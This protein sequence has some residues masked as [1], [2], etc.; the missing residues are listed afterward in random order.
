MIYG[1]GPFADLQR[2]LDQPNVCFGDL[3]FNA[4]ISWQLFNDKECSDRNDRNALLD[5]AV[6]HSCVIVLQLMNH[7]ASRYKMYCWVQHQ[8]DARVLTMTLTALD[9]LQQP[10][11][12]DLVKLL[13]YK[14]SASDM[15]PSPITRE[16]LVELSKG[17]RPEDSVPPPSTGEQRHT[18]R[19][20]VYVYALSNPS[21][22]CWINQGNVLV[23]AN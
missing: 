7:N 18:L 13:R 2:A 4:S 9:Q 21:N 6:N 14:W 12:G 19:S 23:V 22:Y 3:V 17:V 5:F 16:A 15:L 20:D 10:G 8:C 11:P 1:S